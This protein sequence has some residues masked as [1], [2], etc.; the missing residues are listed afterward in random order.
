MQHKV[1]EALARWWNAA[2]QGTDVGGALWGALTHARLATSELP[3]LNERSTL[4]VDGR[5]AVLPIYRAG[6]FMHHDGGM[7]RGVRPRREPRD[8]G[9]GDLPRRP[10]QP[11]RVLAHEGPLQAAK[12]ALRTS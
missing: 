10:H 12:Q 2:H 1:E 9:P 3:S 5:P 4:C 7:R 6:R 11:R 8:R